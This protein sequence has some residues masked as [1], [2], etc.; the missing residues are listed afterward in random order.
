MSIDVYEIFLGQGQC[1]LET[2][3]GRFPTR[4]SGSFTRESGRIM[5]FL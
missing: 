1:G 3:Y 2:A 5:N 4:G